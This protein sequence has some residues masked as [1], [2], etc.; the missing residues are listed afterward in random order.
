MIGG[1]NRHM[2]MEQAIN[3]LRESGWTVDV[4]E[5]TKRIVL[6]QPLP[7][8]NWLQLLRQEDVVEDEWKDS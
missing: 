1:R 4:D 2:T 6:H 5:A 7:N 8:V 3:I